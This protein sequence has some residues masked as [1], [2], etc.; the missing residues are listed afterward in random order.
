METLNGAHVAGGDD[1]DFAGGSPEEEGT[2]FVEAEDLAMLFAAGGGE[3]DLLAEVEAAG[4]PGFADGVE[5]FL[6]AVFHGL[7]KRDEEVGATEETSGDKIE[8]GGKR[9][10]F[11]RE[12]GGGVA[13]VDADAD[14]GEGDAGTGRFGFDEEPGEFFTIEEEVVGPFDAG[15]EAGEGFD[16]I[17][18]GNA[19]EAGEAADLGD[20]KIGAEEDG[21]VEAA[22]G[23]G[24][25][26]AAHAAAATGLAPGGD[27]EASAGA[28]AGLVTGDVVGGGGFGQEKRIPGGALGQTG[29]TAENFLG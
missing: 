11:R 5:G 4:G 9:A 26:G 2:G 13:E 15:A 14:D 21:D 23:R 28:A 12:V 6:Q 10:D 27:N 24:F 18:G 7:Q 29:A 25:P 16:G 20:G 19:G 22:F 3:G 1:F 17:D 8:G